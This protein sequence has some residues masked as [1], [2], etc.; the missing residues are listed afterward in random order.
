MEPRSKH[1]LNE[2]SHASHWQGRTQYYSEKGQVGGTGGAERHQG[3]DNVLGSHCKI[4]GGQP[5]TTVHCGQM[6]RVQ[7]GYPVRDCRGQAQSWVGGR[8]DTARP[9]EAEPPIYIK[10]GWMGWDRGVTEVKGLTGGH[11]EW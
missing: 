9:E 3:E 4:T 5:G 10:D 2:L 8:Q 1:S 11:E 7:V 6:K